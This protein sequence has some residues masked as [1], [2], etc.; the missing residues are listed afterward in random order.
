MSSSEKVPTNIQEFNTVVGLVFAQ[1]YK[2]FP[3]IK[4]LDRLAIARAMGVPDD[5]PVS[6]MMPSGMTFAHLWAYTI[7][8][9]NDEGFIR[10][11]GS[12]PAAHVVLTHEGLRALNVV[13]QGLQQSI[14][15][16]VVET[17]GRGDLSRIG[18]LVGGIFG[19]FTKSITG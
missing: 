4:D 17:S 10:S 13:P 3:E 7:K 9:L 19:G 14:G 6:Y 15:T 16:A 1:L 12:H 2:N 5:Q 11:S 18:D 8:W